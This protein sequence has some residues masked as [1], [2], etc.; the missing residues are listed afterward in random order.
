M[1]A[2][3]EELLTEQ[4]RQRAAATRWRPELLDGALRRHKVRRTRGLVMFPVLA[5]GIAAA[6]ALSVAVAVDGRSPAP[7]KAGPKAQT[8][9][10]VVN[11]A[12]SAITAADA[13]VLEVQTRASYG[14]SYTLWFE[15]R[16]A[17]QLKADVAN[18]SGRTQEVFA[19]GTRILTLDF[20]TRTWWAVRL[21][22]DMRGRR[23]AL[24]V[25]GSAFMSLLSVSAAGLSKLALPTPQNLR[26]ELTDGTF[27]LVGTEDIGGT[28]LLH[29]QGDASSNRGINMWVNTA[30]YLPVRSSV[31]IRVQI[32]RRLGW[33]RLSSRLT[34]LPATAANLAA[35]KPSIPAGFRH[36]APQCPCG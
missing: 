18:K 9:A 35:L 10:Y 24:M 11:R 4:M 20:Q 30:T 19:T 26:S 34:W 25:P 3:V 2:D 31:L 17:M 28:R 36:R 7:A 13:D 16:P 1:N 32:G 22:P 12:R 27:R 29:L 14:W 6:V 33:Q 8:V 23:V 15:I 5:V 21:P